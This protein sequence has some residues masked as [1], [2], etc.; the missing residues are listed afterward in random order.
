[1]NKKGITSI[2]EAIVDF[3]A[4]DPSNTTFQRLLGGATVN[5]A[6]GIRRHSIPSFYL[7]KLGK[8]ETSQFVEEKLMK[9]DVDLSFSSYHV[10]KKMC[11]VY[12]H[13]NPIGERHF[14]SYINETPDEWLTSEELDKKPFMRSKIFYFGSGT[15]FHPIARKTTE[16]A[17]QYA[18]EEK[19]EIAFDTNIRLK[20]WE[21]ENQCRETILYYVNKA[22]IVK[23]TEDE[24][25]FLTETET[26]EKGLAHVAK[27]EIPFLFI[28][29]GKDGA[30]A[31]H[32]HIMVHVPGISVETVDTTGAGDAFM[33][34]LLSC[35]HDRGIPKTE[36]QLTDY[37]KFAN[38]AGALSATKFGSL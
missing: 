38:K 11:S 32:K 27:M 36:T 34:A 14:H 4:T 22:D 29:K 6:V 1:M 12:I 23:M 20:R 31:I 35:F 8:D 37:T 25:L 3:I 17:L 30:Y 24:L 18:K 2:G 15:L 9:E 26:L 33:A 19:M 13:L 7:C 5:V 16:Q 10:K 21:S 28:T